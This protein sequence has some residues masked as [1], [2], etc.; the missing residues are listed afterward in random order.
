MFLLILIGCLT[1]IA[2]LYC[3]YKVTKIMA[4]DN[5]VVN[6]RQWA[7]VLDNYL[8]AAIWLSAIFILTADLAHWIFA[9]KYWD[10]SHKLKDIAEN[11]E[12]QTS[13]KVWLTQA[14]NFFMWFVIMAGNCGYVYA[15]Y[16]T[17]DSL[18]SNQVRYSHVTQIYCDIYSILPVSIAL[19]FL[20]D[21]FRRMFTIRAIVQYLSW[22]KVAA[23]VT[24]FTMLVISAATIEIVINEPAAT[25]ENEQKQ[26][27][28][29][30]YIVQI[31]VSQLAIISEGPLI[32]I[33]WTIMM[34]KVSNTAR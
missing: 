1:G 29:K 11:T 25:Q 7:P 28:T 20:V 3:D 34:K 30:D 27:W 2:L 21:A 9:I 19:V 32:Y 17:R 16:A 12:N 33:I 10:L 22:R 23:H 15:I 31:F 4:S 13:Y 24:I 8:L 26:Q 18:E 14:I 6:I 5:F